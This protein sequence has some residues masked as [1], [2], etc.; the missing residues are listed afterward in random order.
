[1]NVAQKSQETGGSRKIV[2]STARNVDMVR[3]AHESWEGESRAFS[4]GGRHVVA[5]G[6]PIVTHC[7]ASS[8]TATVVGMGSQG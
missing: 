8:S 6:M 4:V 1:M 2:N 5:V 3:G 7:C